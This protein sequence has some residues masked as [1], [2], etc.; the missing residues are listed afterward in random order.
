MAAALDV[1]ERDLKKEWDKHK[2]H[3]RGMLSEIK[4]WGD[5]V[6][7]T[8]QLN[9]GVV[10]FTIETHFNRPTSAANSA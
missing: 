7:V 6:D 5:E 3:I 9:A 10:S 4:A 8:V 2:D 1:L